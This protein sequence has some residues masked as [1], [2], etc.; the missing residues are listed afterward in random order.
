V[1]GVRKKE[2][3]MEE[4][5][6]EVEDENNSRKVVREGNGRWG[7]SLGKIG[8]NKDFWGWDCKVLL[9]VDSKDAEA[10]GGA[11]ALG[12]KGFGKVGYGHCDS[13]NWHHPQLKAKSEMDAFAN[14]RAA[15]N[16]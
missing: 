8:W 3:D 11:L 16:Y 1:V 5:M 15:V 14:V 13:Q 2:E 9:D 12:Q 10:L 4:D 7:N 6:E